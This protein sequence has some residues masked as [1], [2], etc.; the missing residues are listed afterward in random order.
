MTLGTFVEK[1]TVVVHQLGAP[2]EMKEHGYVFPGGFV[3]QLVSV[4]FGSWSSGLVQD[5]YIARSE[6]KSRRI[7]LKGACEIGDAH[8]KM[9]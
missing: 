3:D 5:T 7:K 1:E 8:S 9:S 6:V 2:I 4:N